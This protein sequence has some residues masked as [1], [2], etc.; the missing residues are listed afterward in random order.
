MTK[1]RCKMSESR[2]CTKVERCV[3]TTQGP[4]CICDDLCTRRRRE[5]GQVCGTDMKT[6]A[7]ECKLV[8]HRCEVKQSGLWVAHAGPCNGMMSY[9]YIYIIDI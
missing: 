9:I 2:R 6:Y 4:T 1:N 7:N 3:L 5:S 8:K